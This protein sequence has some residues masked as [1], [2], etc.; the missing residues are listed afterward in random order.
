MI[1]GAK[2]RS[3]IECQKYGMLNGKCRL[4]GGLSPKG[5]DHWNH[6]HGKCTK[7]RRAK[8]KESSATIKYLE[9][10]MIQLGMIKI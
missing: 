2:T 3:G 8:N 10:L 9:S 1:C 7:E 4:H 6:Q 5:S